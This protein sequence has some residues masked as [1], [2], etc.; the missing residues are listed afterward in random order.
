M[1]IAVVEDEQALAKALKRGFESET[2]AVDLFPTAT[3]ARENLLYSGNSY[4]LILLDLMLPDGDG[5]EV[6]KELRATGVRTP[7]LVL[8]AKD[9][10]EDKV[11]LLDRGADDFMTKPFSF[12]ELLARGRALSRRATADLATETII[13]DLRIIPGSRQAYRAGKL[14]SLTAREFD[15]LIY[16]VTH[17]GTVVDREELLAKVWKQKDP[18]VTNVVDVHVRNLRKKLDDPYEHKHIQTSHGVGYS[19]A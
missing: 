14:L 4:D 19:I 13:G 16:L 11:D 7:I 17:R 10:T 3:L 5:A 18:G 1:R 6:C 9:T 2:Y 8:T 12:E 15:L